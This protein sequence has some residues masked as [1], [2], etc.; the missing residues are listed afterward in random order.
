MKNIAH[1][2]DAIQSQK[3]SPFALLLSVVAISIAV[4]AVASIMACSLPY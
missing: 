1:S 3:K 4:L 2:S